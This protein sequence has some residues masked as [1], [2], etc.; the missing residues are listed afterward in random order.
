[1]TIRPGASGNWEIAANAAAPGY[2][3]PRGSWLCVLLKDFNSATVPSP[4]WNSSH[5][6]PATVQNPTETVVSFPTPGTLPIDPDRANVLTTVSGSM[7]QNWM[8]QIR[9]QS[10]TLDIHHIAEIDSQKG[11]VKCT[12]GL[13]C[14]LSADAWSIGQSGI[15]FTYSVKD[16]LIAAFDTLTPEQA[17]IC[18]L[19]G[20][21][22]FPDAGTDIALT[23]G[24]PDGL[25]H[26]QQT[27]S[28]WGYATCFPYDQDW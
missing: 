6:G 25:W 5:I 2:D 22:G 13:D 24:H 21:Q 15:K 12:T 8:D 7:S 14:Q 16:E 10:D 11:E 23:K 27:G 3:G 28:L 18:F 4:W 1:M 17:T 19:S 9:L 20:V 26:V